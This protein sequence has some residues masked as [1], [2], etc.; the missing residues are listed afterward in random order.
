MENGSESTDEVSSEKEDGLPRKDRVEKR[1][2]PESTKDK[3][4]LSDQGFL[5][6]YSA[7]EACL[8]L[9]PLGLPA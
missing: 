1:P 8:D 2:C 3:E 9:R 4:A 6:A 5:P 7:T